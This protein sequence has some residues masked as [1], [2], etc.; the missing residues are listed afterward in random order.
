MSSTNN[1][2]SSGAR[3]VPVIGFGRRLVAALLDGFLVLFFTTILGFAVSFVA[4]IFA[5]F[6]PYEVYPFTT[7]ITWV[8][9]IFSLVYFIGFWAKSGQTIGKSML[10]IRVVGADG[11]SLSWGKALL[12]Y[13]G[14]LVSGIVASIG[15]MWV[16]FDGKRQGWHDK[17]AGSYVVD[18]DE[19]ISDI[20][21]VE[22]VPTD[23]GQSWIWIVIWIVIALAVPAALFSSLFILGPTVNRIVTGW[24]GA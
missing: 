21:A 10:G 5:M 7:V 19:E 18:A 12:R 17:I 13:I 24:L 11:Q 16:A 22:L 6:K 20:N 2:Q 8:G 9:L 1:D 15:F 14:Y 4:I 23:P 3:I